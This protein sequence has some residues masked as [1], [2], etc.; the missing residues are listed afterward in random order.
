MVNGNFPNILITDTSGWTVA[1][2]IDEQ[3][4][5]FRKTRAR[6]IE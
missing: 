4:P 6:T 3:P 5:W 2:V 1:F